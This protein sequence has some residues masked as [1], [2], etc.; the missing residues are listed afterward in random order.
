[1]KRPKS[2]VDE[3][4][5]LRDREHVFTDRFHAAEVLAGMLT[6]TY[7]QVE[8]GVILTIPSGGVPIGIGLREKLDLPMDLL[9]VRKLQIPGNTEAGFGA[10]TLDGRAFFND[11]LLAELHLTDLQIAAE[12][13]R[14]ARELER[15][16]ALFRNNRSFPDLTGKRVILVDDG[17]ASGFTMLAS[18]DLVRRA[19]PEETVVAVPTAPLRTVEQISAQADRV[20]CANIRT[21][22]FFA[23]ANAYQRWHD[24]TE[25]EVLSLLSE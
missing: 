5:S 16:N 25:E 4:E 20:Y 18:V 13:Q 8:D 11:R 12:K 24:L 3:I 15:R 7:A 23:V 17:L 1:M 19:N 10:M 21:T 6:S 2:N 14:V 22:H 9:I